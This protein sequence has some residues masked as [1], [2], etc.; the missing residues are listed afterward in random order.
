[1]GSSHGFDPT[2]STSGYVLWINKRGIMID[3]PPRSSLVLMENSIAPSLIDAVIVTHCHADHGKN[4]NLF[5]S[6]LNLLFKS[7]FS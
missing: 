5:L 1:M 4:Y 2:S 3:P 7:Y 6:Y